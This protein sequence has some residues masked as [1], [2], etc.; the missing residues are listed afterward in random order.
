MASI[1]STGLESAPSIVH[2]VARYPP[3]LGGME[4]AVHAIARQQHAEGMRVRVITT[5]QGEQDAPFEDG[6]IPVARLRSFV[7]ANTP[8]APSL[9]FRLLTLK[10]NCIV[11]L[12]IAQAYTPELVWLAARLRR[13]KYVAHFHADV[14]PSGRAG[15]VLEPY[16]RLVLSR[17]MRGSA[18]VLVPTEDYRDLVCEKY[19]LPRDRVA[20][21]DNGSSHRIIDQPK[22]ISGSSSKAKLLFVGRLAIQKNV[23]LLLRAVAAYRD[24]YGKDFQLTLVGDG[25]LRPAIEAEISRLGLGSYVNLVGPRY[26]AALE[27]TYDESDLLVLTSIF[28]SFGLVLLEGMAKAL[29]IVS[30]RI[31]AVRNI[32]L[33]EVN[34][35]L[36]E[37]TPEALAH[38]INRLLT[39]EDLYAKISINNLSASRRF[40][41]ASVVSKISAAYDSLK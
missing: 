13:T 21:V 6:G 15:L 40:T 25:D 5:S 7:A 35:L 23:P 10:R 8:I 41:W 18:K 12:H 11:H 39:D 9:L 2:V 24:T 20:V 33:D 3:A 17:V 34:G 36:V 38:A 22:S 28:E 16:K 14:I 26:G 27:S 29:P 1:R 4:T 32:I 31:P 37:S 30:V 19:Q